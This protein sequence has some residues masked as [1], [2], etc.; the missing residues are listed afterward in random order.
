M[1]TQPTR[2]SA[3]VG[4]PVVRMVLDHAGDYGS[5]WGPMVSISRKTG[6]TA[7]TLGRWVRRAGRD[8]GRS[9][10]DI[11]ESRVRRPALGMSLRMPQRRVDWPVSAPALPASTSR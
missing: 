8:R 3:E 1:G 7:V 2:Y 11:V 5:Q 4:E 10:A 6:C 9:R